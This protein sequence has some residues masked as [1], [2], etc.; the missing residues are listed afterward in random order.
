[1]TV[2]SRP[3]QCMYCARWRSAFGT[4][5]TVQKCEAFPKGIPAQIW[6]NLADHREPYDGD[7]GLHWESRNGAPFPEMALRLNEPPVAV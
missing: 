1:M 4:G 2:L 5:I 7:N 6:A 3:P